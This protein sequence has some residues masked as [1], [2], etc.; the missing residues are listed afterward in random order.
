MLGQAAHLKIYFP[1]KNIIIMK[2]KATTS[3]YERPGKPLGDN[4][5]DKGMH[6]KVSAST[7]KNI[8]V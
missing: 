7:G 4:P 8:Y 3:I 6:A 5:E 2:M 1:E